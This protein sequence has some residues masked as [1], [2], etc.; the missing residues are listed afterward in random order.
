MRRLLL[1]ILAVMLVLPATVFAAEPILIG[2]IFDESGPGANVGTPTRLVAE[3]AIEDINAAGGILGRPLKLI[4]FDSESDANKALVGARKLTEQDKVLAIVGPT[5]TGSGMA[6]KTY[7][8]EQAM[9]TLMTVGG[10]VVLEGGGKW[11]FKVPQRTSIAVEKIYQHL[12]AAGI[13][14]VGLLTGQDGFGKDGK[15]ALEA[16]AATFGMTI[17]A[18]EVMDRM[19]PDFSAQVFKLAVAKP[20]AIIVW[21]IGP[22]GA[23][24]AKNLAALPGERPLLV[25][26]HG[27]PDPKYIEL[28][29]PAAEGT[30]M[31][32]TKVMALDYLADADPQK[33]VVR[34]FV[35]GYTSRGLDKKFPINT[36]SGYA[37]DAMLLLKAGLSKAGKADRAALRGALETI[38]AMPGVSG[39]FTVTPQ[40]HN[41]LGLD[42]LVMLAVKDGRF[43][44]AR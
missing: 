26:S 4:S 14:R 16:K 19:A 27:Q 12:K 15:A 43:T 31:P 33:A 40:D 1:M 25:Q 24:V 9:P 38:A 21:A 36:H 32:G 2:G 13:T 6:I 7:I 3:M 28:A 23:I 35:Q 18:S 22:A 11:T 29:G 34:A 17:A 41:G 8:E 39:V 30:I 5:L 10:D 37:Y 44:L 42:S 20:Q